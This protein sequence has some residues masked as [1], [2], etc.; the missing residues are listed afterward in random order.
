MVKFYEQDGVENMFD[1]SMRIYKLL[2]L[3]SE[4]DLHNQKEDTSIE[5]TIRYIRSHVGKK[6]TLE[7][8]SGIANLSTYYFSHRFKEET[9]LSPIDYVINT[10]LDQA[11]IL[12]ARTAMTV[13]EIAYE[14]GYQSSNSLINLFNQKLGFSPKEYRKL[15]K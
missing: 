13:E 9:G 10:R 11:K 7:E 4:R 12:L 15:E 5:K 1:S 3:L 2:Q 8:L 6:I 14:V